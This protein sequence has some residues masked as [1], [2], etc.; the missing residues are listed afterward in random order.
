MSAARHVRL[1]LVFRLDGCLAE[2]EEILLVRIVNLGVRELVH[3]EENTPVS[4]KLIEKSDNPI[5]RSPDGMTDKKMRV[6]QPSVS[7]SR[8]LTFEAAVQGVV[9]WVPGA[10]DP[11]A[12]TDVRVEF[13]AGRGRHGGFDFAVGFEDLLYAFA[14]PLLGAG[15]GGH[16]ADLG[17]E[18]LH[19]EGFLACGG[20]V[21]FLRHCGDGWDCLVD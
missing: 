6:I 14:S 18:V 3:V 15:A 20:G 8:Y 13:L 19:V 2:E 10:S 9:G 17:F 7:T 5:F 4:R 21:G 1:T 16:H 11:F 12:A